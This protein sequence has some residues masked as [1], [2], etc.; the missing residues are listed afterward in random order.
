MMLQMFLDGTRGGL[1]LW[2]EAGEEGSNH[3]H[4]HQQQQKL[5]VW[6]LS[7][8]SHARDTLSKLRKRHRGVINLGI[9]KEDHVES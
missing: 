9:D 7:S 3:H 2:Q 8:S 6:W 1:D 5:V 4:H